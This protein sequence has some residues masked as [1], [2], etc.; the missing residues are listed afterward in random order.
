MEKETTLS[1]LIEAVFESQNHVVNSDHINAESSSVH[2]AVD[3]VI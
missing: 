1:H 3:E 2:H